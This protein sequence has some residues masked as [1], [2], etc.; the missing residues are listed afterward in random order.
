MAADNQPNISYKWFKMGF[1]LTELILICDKN[2]PTAVLLA[3]LHF[4]GVCYIFTYVCGLL[5]F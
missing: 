5:V 2:F 3:F 1:H 4:W